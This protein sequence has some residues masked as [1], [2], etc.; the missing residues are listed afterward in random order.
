M[1]RTTRSWI[2]HK[3]WIS[4]LII[5]TLLLGIFFRFVNIEKKYYW[6]DETYTSFRINGYLESE[7]KQHIYDGQIRRVEEIQNYQRPNPTKNLGDVVN[8]LARRPEHSPLYFL[9][10]SF[11][12]QWF[13]SSISVTRTLAAVISLLTFPSLYWLC[14]EL[15]TSPGTAW[16]AIALFAVSPFHVLYAQE[17]RPYSLFTV[18]IL[19]SSAALLQ[20][21]R[22]KTHYSWV[23]YALTI[24]LGL[25]T[26]LFFVLVAV[27]HAIYVITLE[28][29]RLTKELRTYLLTCLIG[30]LGFLPWVIV[31]VTRP[32]F[33]T[34]W[35]KLL[36]SIDRNLEGISHL[37]GILLSPKL[38]VIA[39]VN[40]LPPRFWEKTWLLNFSRS[41]LDLNYIQSDR[42]P[43]LYTLVILLIATLILYS[44]YYLLTHTSKRVGLLI[45]TLV[46]TTPIALIMVDLLLG[47]QKLSFTR[48]L[49]PSFIGIQIAISYL[50]SSKITQFPRTHKQQP[51][52]TAIAIA[53]IFSGILSCT[54]SSQ[55]Y[56]WWNKGG[57]E[58]PVALM[59][60]Q[61]IQ[62]LL[63]SDTG[64]QHV[65]AISY[66]LDPKVKLQLVTEPNVPQIPKGF[67]D[68]F[69]YRPSQILR[70]QLSQ[71]QNYQLR[72]VQE[73]G[74]DR[75]IL[76]KLE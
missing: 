4:I 64:M 56:F 67:S 66:L 54:I 9:M 69:L 22:Q 18:V 23:I 39:V 65:L 17:A 75:A 5:L 41:F 42:F 31:V 37:S 51:L 49:I 74:R 28:N 73:P 10:A 63:V 24:I 11:A 61:T 60:N 35:A 71:E 58:S 62:P 68:I 44:I 70:D 26:H 48:Y 72:P 45:V 43:W 21:I 27:G 53:L 33:P 76:W 55:A 34:M 30:I 6:G 32:W 12:V 25:Y 36:A 46:G 7:F 20:A 59:I 19:L 52:W 14:R 15:F 13:G 3:R 40:S 29:F 57:D 38:A 47:D 8:A 16:I 2:T 1:T 50:L